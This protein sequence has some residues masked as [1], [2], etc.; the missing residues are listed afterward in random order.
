MFLVGAIIFSVYVAFLIW[1]I[2]DSA[3]KNKRD[4]Y[5]ELPELLDSIDYDSLELYREMMSSRFKNQ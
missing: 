2:F 5:P 4:N 1:N 3:K